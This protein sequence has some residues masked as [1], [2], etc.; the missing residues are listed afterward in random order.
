MESA[1]FTELIFIS[2]EMLRVELPDFFFKCKYACV[3]LMAL[4]DLQG[5]LN[6]SST[7]RITIQYDRKGRRFDSL[8]WLFPAVLFSF[9]CGIELFIFRQRKSAGSRRRLF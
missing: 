3:A 2:L 5:I 6:F 9:S 7:Q 4:I 8:T 1:E